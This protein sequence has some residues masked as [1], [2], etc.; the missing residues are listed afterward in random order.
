MYGIVSIPLPKETSFKFVHP[1]K[2]E[3]APTEY[4]LWMRLT[5]SPN[6]HVS[7]DVQSRKVS[8][9]T[10]R[11][12]SPSIVA[13]RRPLQPLNAAPSVFNFVDVVTDEK[14]LHPSNDEAPIDSATERVR[15]PIK[16]KQFLKAELPT[17]FTEVNSSSPLNE[18]QF[19]NA[20]ESI[21]LN[22][23]ESVQVVRL[24]Q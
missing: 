9:V 12:P 16:E 13:S 2:G 1:K 3:Y 6:V 19:S 7:S 15:L 21:V 11:L 18:E 4:A 17:I 14:P 10:T 20:E 24:E 8:Y 5:P 22:E 23:E